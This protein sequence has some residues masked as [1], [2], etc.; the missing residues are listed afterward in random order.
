MNTNRAG[1]TKFL[2]RC[3]K[4]VFLYKTQNFKFFDPLDKC[5]NTHWFFYV[6]VL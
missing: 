4:F 6:K 3:P 5:A 2:G 1:G